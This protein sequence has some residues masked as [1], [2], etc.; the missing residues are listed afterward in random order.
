MN[1]SLN[2]LENLK[3]CFISWTE[4]KS[5]EPH[6]RNIPI[7]ILKSAFLVTWK[8]LKLFLSLLSPFKSHLTLANPEQQ[9]GFLPPASTHSALHNSPAPSCFASFQEGAEKQMTRLCAAL[10]A[11]RCS[12]PFSSAT[13]KAAAQ[14]RVLQTRRQGLPEQNKPGSATTQR[15]QELCPNRSVAGWGWNPSPHQTGSKSRTIQLLMLSFSFPFH[16]A[17][18]PAA[19]NSDH[20]PKRHTL[21]KHKL[22]YKHTNSASC[23]CR[24]LRSMTE[25]GPSPWFSCGSQLH[26]SNSITHLLLSA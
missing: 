10:T 20:G 13:S 23:S 16:V 25:R 8:F 4:N 14:P 26:L 12:G 5:K 24:Q 1:S 9:P 21:R 2:R 22:I 7:P 17:R 3:K 19:G 6:N 18:A 11:T 15:E